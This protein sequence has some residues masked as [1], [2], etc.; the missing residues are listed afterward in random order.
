[1]PVT[2]SAGAFLSDDNWRGQQLADRNQP[3]FTLLRAVA[4]SGAATE[5]VRAS[6]SSCGYNT[7]LDILFSGLPA[8]VFPHGEGHENTRMK[9]AGCMERMGLLQVLG[10]E[11]LDGETL[12]NG[13]H[14]IDT[15]RPDSARAVYA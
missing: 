8:L 15:S 7:T 12:A 13:S 6:V 5:R 3:G 10:T 2:Y 14:A 11:G 4:D 9:R 1:M